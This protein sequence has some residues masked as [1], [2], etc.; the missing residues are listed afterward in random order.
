MYTLCTTEKTALQQWQFE[1]AF[2][3]YSLEV[4]YDDIT[5]SELCRRAGLSRKIFY[6]LFDRKAD[7][8]YA[9]LDHT[10][11]DAAGYTPDPS[12]G[13]GELHR[14]LAF[15]RSQKPLLDVLQMN[16]SS[17]MLTEAA[18]RHMKRE[19]SKFLHCFGTDEAGYGRE[20]LLFYVSGIFS[21][22]LDWHQQDFSA[23]IDQMA[24]ALMYLLSTTPIKH[25]LTN[26]EG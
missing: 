18:I 1:Q 9:L 12:V 10:M 25:T 16:R 4:P 21:L 17:S 23:S 24:D 20:I 5:I 8:L 15:W 7:V 2:L 14:F 19:N 26:S 3:E 13:P 22:L 11:L 6:R